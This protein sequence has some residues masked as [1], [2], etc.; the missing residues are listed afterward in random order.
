MYNH[1]ISCEYPVEMFLKQEEF[2]LILDSYPHFYPPIKTEQ[3]NGN[4]L[5]FVEASISEYLVAAPCIQTYSLT[6]KF[7]DIWRIV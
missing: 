6:T 2:E 7:L 4:Y 1:P 3:S 5:E